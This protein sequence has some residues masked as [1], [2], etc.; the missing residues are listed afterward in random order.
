V[1]NLVPTLVASQGGPYAQMRTGTVVSFTTNQVRVSAGGSTFTAAYL[2]GTVLAAGSLVACLSQGGSW[3]VLGVL[4]GVGDNLLAA[5]NPSFEDSAPGTFPALWFQAN[6]S[7]VSTITVVSDTSAPTGSQV[8]A[9]GGSVVGTQS[10]LYSQP[11]AVT[12]GEQFTLSA[13]A[14]GDYQ[15]G[16]AHTADAALVALWFANATNLYPTTSAVDTTVSTATDLVQ[17]PPYTSLGGTV[18]APVT[19]FMRVAL[20]ST[21]EATQRVRWDGVIVRKV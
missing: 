5:G 3:L 2:K 15:P 14:G 7:G 16:D 8:A 19:G 12:S 11:I 13:F 21:T 4:A 10:Y 1:T 18:T 9:V 17:A 6:L 20:R